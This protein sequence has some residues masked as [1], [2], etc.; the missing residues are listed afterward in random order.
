MKCT[1]QH[2]EGHSKACPAYKN[3]SFDEYEFKAKL[4]VRIEE[5]RKSR[6]PHPN[7][8]AWSGYETA[9]DDILTLIDEL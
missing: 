9:V 5:Q 2:T 7:M 3:M 1:C 4:K 8:D 6:E